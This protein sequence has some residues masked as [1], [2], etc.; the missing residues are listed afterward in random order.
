MSQYLKVHQMLKHIVFSQKKAA[1][2]K[3]CMHMAETKETTP[4]LVLKLVK[5]RHYIVQSP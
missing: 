5:I 3:K 2:N 1:R 4:L